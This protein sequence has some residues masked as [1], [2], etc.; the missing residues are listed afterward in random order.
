MSSVI[1]LFFREDYHVVQ[2]DESVFPSD[3]LENDVD[4]PL[5]GSRGI[6]KTE[7]HSDKLEQAV[8][9]GEVHLVAIV[10]LDF[11]LAVAAVSVECRE[12][13]SVSQCVNSFVHSKY[14]VYISHT[15][16]VE[17]SIVY[18]EAEFPVLLCFKDDWHRPLGVGRFH[19]P[20]FGH[21]FKFLLFKHTGGP[22]G[23]VRAIPHGL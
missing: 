1:G 15:H 16:C 23:S 9:R 17:F 22:P 4:F 5:K 14:G 20:N 6:L 19:Y 12:D 13:Y 11:D 2:A 8:M 21:L 10:F 18:E 7:R 3:R